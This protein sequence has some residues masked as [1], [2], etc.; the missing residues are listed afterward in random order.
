MN[1]SE[2]TALVDR[3]A[4][5]SRALLI[6][7]GPNGAGKSTFV[8]RYVHRRGMRV[9]NP[10][11]IAKALSPSAPEELAYEA[12]AVAEGVRRDLLS[13][14][15]SF[16]METVFSDPAG[17]KLMFLRSAQE[18]GYVIYLV[19]IGLHSSQ[20]AMGRVKERTA[21]GGHGVP[22]EK[23]AQRFPRTLSNLHEALTFVDHAFVFDNSSAE[24]PYRFIAE[25]QSG[26]VVRLG[27][28]QP[29]WWK[30]IR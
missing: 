28:Y 7:A 20:L 22:T 25:L 21:R 6:V 1:G 16:C 18:R 14:G 5:E 12:A 24:R 10:D 17:E 2:R 29:A 19:Y 11:S 8:E 4:A 30:A 23:I 27:Y 15:I 9:V 26:R 13:R 3:V